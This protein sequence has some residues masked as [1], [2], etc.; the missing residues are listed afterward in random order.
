MVLITKKRLTYSPPGSDRI[1]SHYILIHEGKRER[2][3][4]SHANLFL[5]E[6]TRQSVKTS[7]R[8]ASILSMFYRYLSTRDEFKSKPPSAYHIS[9]LNKHVKRWQDHREIE[10]IRKNSTKPSTETIFDDAMII[11]YYFRWLGDRHFPT[12]I[13]VKLKT[14]IPPF[15]SARYQQYIS[16]KARDIIDS[17]SIRT[18]DKLNR[19]ASFDGLITLQEIESLITNYTDPVYSS[20]LLFALGTAMRPMDLCRFPYYGNGKNSHIMPFSSMG[21]DQ[22]TTEYYVSDSKGNK[23][24]TIQIHRDDLKALEE[25]YIKLLYPERALKYEKKYGQKPPLS[26]LFLNHDGD[27]VTPDM[28]SQRTNAA[29]AKAMRTNPKLRPSLTFYDARDWWPTHYIIKAFG[30]QLLNSNEVLFNYAVA[31]ILL[32]QMGHSSLRTTFK[33]YIALATVILSIYRGKSTEILRADLSTTGFLC[34]SL[35]FKQSDRRNEVK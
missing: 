11:M 29:K 24:R 33:H 28:I 15:K 18:L 8:Y 3:L 20:L 31:Q 10:R 5:Y 6:K 13:Q 17:T 27:P 1:V 19:Q 2:T 23:S 25:A 35:E 22:D 14:W 16:L 12:A 21:M 7:S 32:S 9:V 30:D 26:L 4:L 34:K